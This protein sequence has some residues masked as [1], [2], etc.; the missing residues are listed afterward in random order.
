MFKPSQ[1]GTSPDLFSSYSQHLG[2]RKLNQLEDSTAW[3]NCFYQEITSRINER[4]FAS[5]YDKG[6]GRP[7][8]SVRRLVAMLILKEGNDWTDEQLF[9]SCNFNILIIRALGL[10]N[11]SDSIPCAATYYNFKLALLNHKITTGDD[12]LDLCFQD[13]TQDQIIRYEVSGKAVRMDSKL[14]HSN[15]AKSTRLQL[16]LGVLRKFYKSLSKEQTNL[17]LTADNELLS[18][19]AEKGVEAYTY[20][21]DK[22]SAAEELQLSGQLLYRLL[23]LFETSTS[24]EYVLLQRLWKDHFEI[25]SNEEDDSTHIQPKDTSKQSGSTLQSVHDPDAAYR[26]K[27]GSKKQIING[28]VINITDTCP[29]I[30]TQTKKEESSDKEQEEE[31][32]KPL[33]LITAVQ[34]EKATHS[35]DK[36]F[37]PAIEQSRKVLQDDI[38][39]ALTD[40]AYNSV[41]NE[42]FTHIEDKELKWYLTA[43]QGA[44][45]YYDFEQV[46]EH[47]YKVTDRRDGSV[48]TTIKTPKGKFR[49]TDHQATT[50]SKYRYFEAKTITNYFRRK[51]ME[52]YPPWVHSFRANS[53][54]TIKQV[55]CKLNGMKSKY[56]GLHQHHIYALN[57]C[58]WVNFKR[59]HAKTIEN[60]NLN[61]LFAFLNSLSI[62]T[63]SHNWKNY[64]LLKFA[65]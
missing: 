65:I 24:E 14:V 15:I 45:G 43:I 20:R 22:K 51:E 52:K 7:N 64:F 3:H 37:K 46:D 5:M 19:V 60:A 55:F 23:S 49:I 53:E 25:K 1:A 4:L 56:R 34:T 30:P 29:P 39:N 2:K 63:V 33:C 26:N 28:F 21:L 61:G 42:Q 41:S 36:F 10:S 57:R 48:Q 62:P 6:N 27:P 59:I 13:L 35:D 18:K 17:L 54:A 58:F 12:L 50:K 16:C 47:T 32:V 44:E 8:A 9:E 11:L 40:G 31:P 38:E